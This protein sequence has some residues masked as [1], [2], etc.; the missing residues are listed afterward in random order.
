MRIS[1][2]FATQ[3]DFFPHGIK[4]YASGIWITNTAEDRVRILSFWKKHGLVATEEAFSVSER[5]PYLWQEKLRADRGKLDALNPVSRAPKTRRVRNW[6][7]R[8]LEEIK[9]LRFKHP[10]LGKERDFAVQSRKSSGELLP[11]LA[12]S[13]LS[14]PVSLVQEESDP[15]IGKRFSASRKISS[16]D[17]PDT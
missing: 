8:I 10:N 9:C 15:F 13:I 16:R 14:R 6:D 12:D 1:I 4:R 3:K 2:S 11:T 7:S 5:T 17:I